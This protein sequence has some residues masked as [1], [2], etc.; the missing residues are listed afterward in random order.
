MHHPMAMD[1]YLSVNL[2]IRAGVIKWFDMI[3]MWVRKENAIC[4]TW[5]ENR[6]IVI[7]WDKHMHHRMAIIIVG[8][9]LISFIH[10][11]VNLI[12]QD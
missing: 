6:E 9:V 10:K 5:F 12:V 1:M 4:I 2:R 11:L 3:A 8:R 7:L